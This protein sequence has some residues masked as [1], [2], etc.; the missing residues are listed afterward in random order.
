MRIRALKIWIESNHTKNLF[1]FLQ[2]TLPCCYPKCLMESMKQL[3]IV[4]NYEGE[5]IKNVGLFKSY[6]SCIR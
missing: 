5:C 6:K 3:I 4:M 1:G 2:M